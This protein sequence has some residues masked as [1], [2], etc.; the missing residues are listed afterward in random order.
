VSA[1]IGTIDEALAG[2]DVGPTLVIAVTV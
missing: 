2:A 1:G